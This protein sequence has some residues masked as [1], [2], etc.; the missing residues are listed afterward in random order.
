M[1]WIR[2]APFGHGYC[3]TVAGIKVVLSSGGRK[4]PAPPNRSFG[5]AAL[6]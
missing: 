2:R 6:D 5:G 4:E 3:S 1:G